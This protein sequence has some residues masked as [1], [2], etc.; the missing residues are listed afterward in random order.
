MTK[1]EKEIIIEE[2]KELLKYKLNLM[3]HSFNHNEI[4]IIEQL[5]VKSNYLSRLMCKLGLEKEE[6]Q[7]REEY[8]VISDKRRKE[9]FPGMY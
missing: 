3:G 2:Y 8:K 5:T 1:H 7:I 4:W 6:K 9:L